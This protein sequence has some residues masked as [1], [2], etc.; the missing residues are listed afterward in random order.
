MTS[1]GNYGTYDRLFPKGG[2][3][4]DSD[5][6]AYL[7]DQAVVVADVDSHPNDD[8]VTVVLNVDRGLLL[9]GDRTEVGENSPTVLQFLVAESRLTDRVHLTNALI[10]A[11]HRYVSHRNPKNLSQIVS[12]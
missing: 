7:I 9:L 12:F 5:P 4:W 3:E 2:F 6:T 11:G 8:N 1:T 10:A